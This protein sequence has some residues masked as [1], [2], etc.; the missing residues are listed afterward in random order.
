MHGLLKGSQ[1]QA[2][3]VPGRASSGKHLSGC[4]TSGLSVCFWPAWTMEQPGKDHRVLEA[5]GAWGGSETWSQ[6]G[7]GQWHKTGLLCS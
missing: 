4:L 1:R 3:S 7:R 5:S 6:H 2:K